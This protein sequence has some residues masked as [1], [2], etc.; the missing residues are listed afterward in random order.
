MFNRFHPVA[1]RF[2]AALGA[3][4]DE[5]GLG[6]ALAARQ[7]GRA[8]VVGQQAHHRQQYQRDPTAAYLFGKAEYHCRL[9]YRRI[10]GRA[11]YSGAGARGRC[12]FDRAQASTA[13]LTRP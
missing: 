8:V 7:V 5:L 9:V 12:V 13:R 3:M 2:G 6:G 1:G 4:L 10:V 11:H